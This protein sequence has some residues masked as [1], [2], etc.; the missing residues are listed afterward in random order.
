[1]T[2]TLLWLGDQQELG[3]FVVWAQSVGEEKEKAT[4]ED[5]VNDRSV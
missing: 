2:T 1:L 3:K 5:G 4:K